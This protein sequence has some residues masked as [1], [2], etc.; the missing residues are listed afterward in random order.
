MQEIFLRRER[1][2]AGRP[3]G[4]ALVYRIFR[5]VSIVGFVLAVLVSAVAC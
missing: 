4:E 5:V 3:Q 1:G 2:P